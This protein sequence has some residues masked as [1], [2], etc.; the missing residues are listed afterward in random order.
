MG[1]IIFENIESV[2]IS[3]DMLNNFNITYENIRRL[4]KNFVEFLVLLEIFDF[5]QTLLPYQKHKIN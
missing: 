4:N 5:Y 2:N 3:F 1:I